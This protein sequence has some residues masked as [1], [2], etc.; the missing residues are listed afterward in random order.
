MRCSARAPPLAAGEGRGADASSMAGSRRTA[1]ASAEYLGE[2]VRDEGEG[3]AQCAWSKWVI[4][5]YMAPSN[6]RLLSLQCSTM[7][8]S[9][10]PAD[11]IAADAASAR[12]T[13]MTTSVRRCV[14]LEPIARCLQ[15]DGHMSQG[16]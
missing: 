14:T 10:T 5:W 3:S 12:A 7:Q 6:M 2:R 4:Y 16:G 11:N 15:G 1:A 13:I 9:A 8:S